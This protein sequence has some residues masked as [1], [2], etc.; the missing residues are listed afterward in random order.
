MDLV[1]YHANCPDGFCAAWLAHW[2]F[3][4]A[5]FVPAHYGDE[6]PDVAGK[7]VLIADFSYKRPVML[8]LLGRAGHVT[9]LDHH[10]TAEAELAGIGSE[11][12]PRKAET[13][14]FDMDKSGG[15]LTW[16]WM[17]REAAH[18]TIGLA[19]SY[20]DNPPWLV[21]YTED[22]DLWRWALPESRAVNAALSSYPRDF[23]TWDRLAARGHGPLIDEGRAI[24]RYQETVVA[25][26]VANAVEID[27]AGHRVLA[28]NAT[29]LFSE[30]A[31]TLAEDRPFGVA[32]FD[33]ADGRRQ[34][35]LRS[36][37]G[38]IDVSEV[39]RRFGGG[40]HM[41]AAGFE[42]MPGQSL[43]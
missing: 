12:P 10:R 21:D 23:A 22:R 15:R 24:L 13:I 2:A 16:E 7:R 11:G 35:S 31:G 25:Q 41:Q 3:P 14:V 26:H 17:V 28:V 20:A 9:V 36:R 18:H 42:A 30:I 37:D 34:F 4:D 33:R 8:D 40:G 38:G 43:A 1:I 32:Y 29:T 39:A 5:E 6:P 19:E 27:L